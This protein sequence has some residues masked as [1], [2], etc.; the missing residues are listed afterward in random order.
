MDILDN[1]FFVL[2][3]TTRDDRRRIMG[4]AEEKCL[5]AE[6]QVA[7]EASS[8][9]SNP[10]KRL[11]AE[12]GW[13]PGIGPRRAAEAVAMIQGNPTGIRDLVNLPPLA[14]ANLLAAGFARA[15]DSISAEEVAE[16]IVE[17]AEADEEVDPEST[18]TLI[19]EERSVAGF[20]LVTD[21][22]ALEAEFGA[23]RQH[24]R[25]AIKNALN[26]LSSADL[27]RVVTEAV[28]AATDGGVSHAP[29]LIDLLVDS[30]EVEAQGF[31]E[32]ET[33]NIA[34]LI[35]QIRAAAAQEQDEA[36]LNRLVSKLERVVTNWDLVAQPIQVS[37]RSRGL[38]HRLSHELAREVR[39]LA[40]DLFNEHDQ[41]QISR[42]L[43]NLI[44]EVFAEVDKV[45]EQT[46]EDA[47][48]LDKIAEQ[49]TEFLSNVK[50]RVEQWRQEITYEAELGLVFKDKLKIS[51]DGVEWKGRRIPLE[52][53]SRLRWGGTKHYVNG[54]PS[55]TSYSIFVGTDR[56]GAS[57]ELKKEKIYGDFIER[58]WKAVG[59]RLLTQMLEGLKEGQRYRF[60]NALIDDYGVELERHHTFRSNEKVRCRW[61]D[62]VIGNAN[63]GF[64][65]A[66]K[67]ERQ[68]SVQLAYQQEDN[69]HLLEAAMRVFWKQT[70]DRMSDLLQ[71]E[72]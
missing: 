8:A 33:K 36:A 32:K 18:M 42:R 16:W 5:F 21:G 67:D 51:P 43:T 22:H 10:R 52:S 4:L 12:V 57:I 50:A 54:V 49:R 34:T 56:D 7:S 47:A 30:F 48:A 63:G 15:V 70:S 31:L 72:E 61:A 41:L 65:I 39:S 1:P 40:V 25:T 64:F 3:A 45:V 2:G 69:V 24:Y 71:Q 46:G 11:A 62:L 20:P 26:H 27:V 38:D 58:L 29:I 19:N 66:K 37:A 60:G 9:L 28:E 53:I 44:Q 6:E 23:R 14:R 59:S 55:G 35:E 68:V 13:L 17:L